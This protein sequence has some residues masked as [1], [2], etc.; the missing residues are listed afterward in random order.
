ML[1]I[2]LDRV[3]QYAREKWEEMMTVAARVE[4]RARMIES[5]HLAR[6]RS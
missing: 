6:E 1:P 5:H 4:K 3:E 2:P